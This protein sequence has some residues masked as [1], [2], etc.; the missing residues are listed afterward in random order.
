MRFTLRSR[1]KVARLRSDP[2]I[3]ASIIGFYLQIKKHDSSELQFFRFVYNKETF[4]CDEFWFP[5]CRTDETNA[6][7]FDSRKDC[8]RIADLCVRKFQKN[9]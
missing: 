3:P 6:N 1:T 5:G 4:E 8:E 7:L 9:F 2:N